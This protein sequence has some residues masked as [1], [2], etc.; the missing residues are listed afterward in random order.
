ML[1]FLFWPFL[2]ISV[3]LRFVHV[4]CVNRSLLFIAEKQSIIGMDHS[5]ISLLAS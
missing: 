5:Y 1:Y 2:L 3:H 4:V